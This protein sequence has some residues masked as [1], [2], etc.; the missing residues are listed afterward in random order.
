MGFE[1]LRPIDNSQVVEES[2]GQKRQNGQISGI[3]VHGRYKGEVRFLPKRDVDPL[4]QE[5]GLTRV[6]ISNWVA[7]S[8]VS[9]EGHSRREFPQR[10]YNLVTEHLKIDIDLDTASLKS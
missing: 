9:L 3:Q 1:P 5:A 10:A 4:V 6:E 8:A 2:S 7:G